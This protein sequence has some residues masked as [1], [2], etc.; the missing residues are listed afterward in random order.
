LHFFIRIIH[1]AKLLGEKKGHQRKAEQM[2]MADTTGM[3]HNRFGM[4]VNQSADAHAA[5]K[6]IAMVAAAHTVDG[7]VERMTPVRLQKNRKLEPETMA[8]CRRT[9]IPFH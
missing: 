1:S 9:S 3:D 6:K 7:D 5:G 4:S 2:D 8:R